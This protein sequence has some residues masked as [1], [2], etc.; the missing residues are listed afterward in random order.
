MRSR[1]SYS[2]CIAPVRI[3]Y[4]PMRT[5]LTLLPVVGKPMKNKTRHCCTLMMV[6]YMP[7]RSPSDGR[8]IPTY[9]AISTTAPGR[10][11]RTTSSRP[12]PRRASPRARLPARALRA[13]WW[14]APPA[15]PRLVTCRW[16][17][18]IRALLPQERALPPVRA[19]RLSGRVE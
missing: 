11:T 4:T 7:F 16:P 18:P 14:V 5:T 15:R 3:V 17:T 2:W 19:L 10:R 8:T 1:C 9:F 13:A 6:S 12:G